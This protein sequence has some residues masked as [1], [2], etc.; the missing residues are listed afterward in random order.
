MF[1]IFAER[2][3]IESFVCESCKELSPWIF[4]S[5]AICCKCDDVHSFCPA[6]WHVHLLSAAEQDRY[7]NQ[8]I[9]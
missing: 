7:L 3:V 4:G 9:G 8:V 5:Q 2:E 1:R 6:C